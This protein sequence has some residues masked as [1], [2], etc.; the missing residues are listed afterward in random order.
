M[1]KINWLM[2]SRGDKDID[3]LVFWLTGGPGCASEIA[4]IIKA[5]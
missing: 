1:L 5:F 4:V 2:R 3:P